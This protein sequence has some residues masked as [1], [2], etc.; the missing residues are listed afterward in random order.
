MSP[1]GR[2]Q[3]QE[4]E[5][6]EA[7]STR[8]KTPK[9]HKLSHAELEKELHGLYL[10]DLK[11]GMSAIIARTVTDADIV[12]FAGISGDTNPLHMSTEFA[13]GTR[14]EG[15]IVHGMLTASLISAAI[16]TKLPGPGCIY[17]SQNQRFLAP[18]RAGDS[19]LARVTI[20][21]INQEKERVTLTTMCT[22]G[23][24]VVVEGEAL[25]KVP[26]RPAA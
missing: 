1:E 12:L 9:F 7:R 11:V 14:F 5:P 6:P 8:P 25:I 17:M 22:V 10:E 15:R 13:N 16:G 23:D 19:V 20:S 4:A 24:T 2:S 18:V 3:S 21:A 26:R